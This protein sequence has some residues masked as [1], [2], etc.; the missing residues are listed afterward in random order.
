MKMFEFSIKICQEFVLCDSI[1]NNSLLFWVMAWYR[2]DKALPE[3]MM[4]R[5]TDVLG[6]V[7]RR[8]N[9]DATLTWG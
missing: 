4:M 9:E 5:L 6:Y 1:D 8:L 7:W 2:G 3:A